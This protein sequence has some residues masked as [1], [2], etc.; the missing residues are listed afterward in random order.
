MKISDI[1]VGYLEKLIENTSKKKIVLWGAGKQV[2]KFIDE[3]CG[4]KK[5]LPL[6]H[7]ILETTRK[8]ITNSIHGIPIVD[9]LE[10]LNLN[11]E[12][13]LIIITAGL[14]ELQGAVVSK[15]FYYFQM[16]HRRSIEAYHFLKNNSKKCDLAISL[17]ADNQ[18]KYIYKKV[19]ENILY[20]IF[21]DQSLFS[22]SP[23]FGNDLIGRLPDRG[24]FVFAGAFNGKHLIRALDNNPKVNILAM[25]PSKNWYQN[26]R[27]KFSN[28]SNIELGNAL[29]WHEK[30]QLGYDED[31]QN[32]GLG[33]CIV[34]DL[35]RATYLLDTTTIDIAVGKR[36]VSEIALDIEGAE[37]SALMGASSTIKKWKPKL[38]I[39]LYHNFDDYFNIPNIINDYGGYKIYIK[40]HSTLSPIETVLY[41]LPEN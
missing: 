27:I 3:Y 23:Y 4:D 35:S 32:N 25:E 26:L 9:S 21:W 10:N 13:T 33:A 29:F 18:S 7:C 8:P 28:I 36:P 37:Q 1:D 22:P 16:I 2:S 17:L 11:S 15:E 12:N 39:C 14:L 34:S 40:Q 24:I 5:L 38:C 19:F 31:S 6:P 30:T 41:A 20:G